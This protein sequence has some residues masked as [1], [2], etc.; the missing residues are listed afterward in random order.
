[1]R[2][3]VAIGPHKGMGFCPD[4]T[5]LVGVIFE[6]YTRLDSNHTS[7]KKI[8]EFNYSHFH[9]VN[10]K[11]GTDLERRSNGRISVINGYGIS[12]NLMGLMIV[13]PRLIVPLR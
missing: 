10:V 9:T 3:A 4:G 7:E 12:N 2:V 13:I 1:V 8:K 6:Y 5:R 11:S